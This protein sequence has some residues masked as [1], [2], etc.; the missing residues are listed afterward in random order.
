MTIRVVLADDQPLVRTGLRV[1][2]GDTA[3][4]E[5]AGEAATGR[6]AVTLTREARP[7]VV[8]M[9]LRLPDLDGIE[10]T[11]IIT[12]DTAGAGTRVL[13]L[14]A[15]DDDGEVYAALR[16][17]ASGFLSRGM[18]AGDVLT[19]IRVAASGGALV[20]PAATCRLV[21]A[22]TRAARGRTGVPAGRAREVLVRLARGLSD[23]EIGGDL[24][25]SPS[26]VG[27]EVALLLARFTA[28]DRVHLLIAAHESGLV[29]PPS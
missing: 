3:D 18:G 5:V 19:A 10:A 28:R 12:G 24:S 25:L 13:V 23:A 29:P 15:A 9:D 14:A 1:L 16:A 27:V 6:E 11:R 20:D 8:L 4:I 21:A 7:D 22:F 2:L 17:G 26:E